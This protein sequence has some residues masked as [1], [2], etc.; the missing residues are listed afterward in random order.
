LALKFL[1]E[2]LPAQVRGA[3]AQ[4]DLDNGVARR[5]V[6]NVHGFKRAF[7]LPG[8]NLMIA[9]SFFATLAFATMQGTYTLFL[10]KQYARPE[11]QN[12]IRTNPKEAGAE[13]H[14]EKSQT[15]SAASEHATA[16]LTGSEGG[17]ANSSQAEHEP[18]P[19]SL[20]G[21]FVWNEQP[22]PEGFTW[23]TVEK[24]LVRTR[25]AQMAAYIF[26]AI[27]IVALITQGGLID[28]LKKRFGEL[29]LIATGTLMMAIGLALI[30]FPHTL[31]GQFPVVALLAFGNSIATPVLTALVSELSPENERGEMIGVFQSVGS[32]G[33]II[34]PNVGGSLFNV[35]GYAVPYMAGGAIM[36][37]SLAFALKLRK[38]CA[39]RIG[40]GAEAPASA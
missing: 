12:F 28:P 22:A 24:M 34:G 5:H 26:A 2:S 14:L 3:N 7:A 11:V 39:N 29:P 15:R 31:W 19:P 37:I 13:A 1:P 20:G 4:T 6:F 16:G 17:T 9:I 27:G 23:R 10:I 8:L 38:A 25:A 21:D 32:L 30:P 18:Y 33:R 40:S 35:F 36:L